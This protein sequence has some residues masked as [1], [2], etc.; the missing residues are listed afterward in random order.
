V[1]LAPD[2]PPLALQVK[3]VVNRP[4][5]DEAQHPRD[6]R[7]RFIQKGAEVRVGYGKI[8]IVLDEGTGSGGASD[9]KITV[10]F[11]DGS[12]GRYD[13]NVLTVTKAPTTAS[14][15][16]ANRDIAQPARPAAPPAPDRPAD[17]EA[18]RTAIQA[19]ADTVENQD[20]ATAAAL[21]AVATDPGLVQSADGAFVARQ[22]DDGGT[23][24]WHVYESSTGVDLTPTGA[25]LTS[26]QERDAAFDTLAR[27]GVDWHAGATGGWTNDA[28][29]ASA[30]QAALTAFA[31]ADTQPDTPTEPG[32]PNQPDQGNAPD[33]TP[34]APTP[35]PAPAPNPADGQQ[36][37]RQGRQRAPR[38]AG[39]GAGAPGGRQQPQQGG[40][41]QQGDAPDG[42]SRFGAFIMSVIAALKGGDK[43]RTEGDGTPEDPVRLPDVNPDQP[44]GPPGSI[45]RQVDH[46]ET[47]ADGSVTV[48]FTDG[49]T[50]TQSGPAD[51]PRPLD[52]NA[53]VVGT[54]DPAVQPG[55]PADRAA[56]PTDIP[57]P[58]TPPI[59]GPSPIG[60]QD[61]Q[62]PDQPAE[63]TPD[64][65][66]AQ[67]AQPDAIPAPDAAP[68]PDQP[69][70]NAR[71]AA[72]DALRRERE[73]ALGRL[74]DQQVED[75]LTAIRQRTQGTLDVTD[76][77]AMDLQQQ[78][79]AL[80][81]EALRRGL[82]SRD[83]QI[84]NGAQD[85]QVRP[86][87]DAQPGPDGVIH[88][89][90]ENPTTTIPIPG[91]PRPRAGE[92]PNAPDPS[93][94]MRRQAAPPPPAP[95]AIP[96]ADPGAPRLGA[97]PRG[98]RGAQAMRDKYGFDDRWTLIGGSMGTTVGRLR[99]GDVVQTRGQGTAAAPVELVNNARMAGDRNNV[100]RTVDRT[101]R[102]ADG[103]ITVHFTDGTSTGEE[104]GSRNGY[105]HSA[106]ER[107]FGAYVQQ[108][109]APQPGGDQPTQPGVPRF[110]NVDALRA[111]LRSHAPEALGTAAGTERE[112]ARVK[113]LDDLANDPSLRLSSDGRL[114]YVKGG[115]RGSGY[116]IL[117]PSVA[118][119]LGPLGQTLTQAEAKRLADLFSGLR[120]ADGQP[121]PWD[122]PDVNTRIASFR[123]ANGENLPQSLTR[124]RASDPTLDNS[125]ALGNGYFAEQVASYDRAHARRAA[126]TDRQSAGG[127]T[128][129][130]RL[131]AFQ[132][133]DRLQATIAYRRPTSTATGGAEGNAYYFGSD[134]GL[135][136]GDRV[137]VEGTVSVQNGV[138]NHTAR[139]GPGATWRTED[140]SRSGTFGPSGL[141]LYEGGST[142][143]TDLARGDAQPDQPTTPDQPTFPQPTG[144]T[145]VIGDRVTAPG[146]P[147]F[148]GVVTR[149]AGSGHLYVRLDSN[150][151]ESAAPADQLQVVEPDQPDQPPAPVEIDENMPADALAAEFDRVGQ[152]D[153]VTRLL[154]AQPGQDIDAEWAAV[155]AAAANPPG[156]TGDDAQ[157]LRDAREEV[158]ARLEGAGHEILTPE[159]RLTL[160]SIPHGDVQTLVGLSSTY[161]SPDR[162]R[163]AA[164][165]EL[166]RRGYSAEGVPNQGSPAGLTNPQPLADLVGQRVAINDGDG[167][168][169]IGTIAAAPQSG[170]YD[171]V[172]ADGEE[173]FLPE[174]PA[175][176]QAEPIQPDDPRLDAVAADGANYLTTPE[177][178]HQI[179]RLGQQTR[180]AYSAARASGANPFEDPAFRAANDQYAS[181]VRARDERPE[182]QGGTTGPGAGQGDLFDQPTDPT[183][184]IPPVGGG[185]PAG[186]QQPTE[187]IPVPQN[188]RAAARI[189]ARR[190]GVPGA[191]NAIANRL[192]TRIT[193]RT[194]PAGEAAIDASPDAERIRGA[195]TAAEAGLLPR[196]SQ[197]DGARAQASLQR[198]LDGD[199][200]HPL[201]AV[202]HQATIQILDMEAPIQV[203]LGGGP[204]PPAA[205]RPYSGT[206]ED[207]HPQAPSGNIY[208]VVNGPEGRHGQ[209]MAVDAVVNVTDA[210]PQPGGGSPDQPVT[211]PAPGPDVPQPGG[212][213]PDG[214]R[215][216][217][218]FGIGDHVTVDGVLPGTIDNIDPDGTVIGLRLDRNGRVVRVTADGLQ[219]YDATP[220]EPTTP[221]GGDLPPA[222]PVDV[223]GADVQPGQR[224]LIDGATVSVDHV[225]PEDGGS[226]LVI[227]YTGDDGPGQITVDPSAVL[228]GLQAAGSTGNEPDEPAPSVID[229]GLSDTQAYASELQPQQ[230]IYVDGRIATVT[231][232]QRSDAVTVDY[233]IGRLHRSMVL[234]PNATIDTVDDSNLPDP[235][236]LP[237][238]VSTARPALQTYQRRSIVAMGLDTHP[239]PVV[240]EAARRVRLRQPL[241]AE[242]ARAL[243]D[244]VR[245]EAGR[246]GVRP[247]QRRS[248]QRQAAVLD[249]AAIQAGAVYDPPQI[250]GQDTVTPLRLTDVVEGNTVAV[251][252]ATGA[253]LSGRV[254]GRRSLMGGRLHEVTVDQPDGT[255]RTLLLPRDAPAFLLPDLPDPTPVPPEGPTREH[256]TVDR[257]N[258][259]DVIETGAES[260][261]ASTGS[262]PW[263]VV[264]VQRNDGGNRYPRATLRLEDPTD[265]TTT[266]TR[267]V[268]AGDVPS[269]IRVERGDASAEQPFD[270]NMPAENPT[271]IDYTDVQAGDRITISRRYGTTTGYVESVKDITG[272]DDKGRPIAG[273]AF[274]VQTD[275]GAT[276][277]DS[278]FDP[279]P[280][281]DPADQPTVMRLV[282]ADEET[283]RARL[284][285]QAERKRQQQ[286]QATAR[287]FVRTDEEARNQALSTVSMSI[288]SGRDHALAILNEDLNAYRDDTS[289]ARQTASSRAR[290][291][292][293]QVAATERQADAI[294]PRLE[295]LMVETYIRG[296]QDVINALEQAHP[297][298]G[299]T[300][301]NMLRRVRD[302]LDSDPPDH[303]WVDLGS[304][305]QRVQAAL[306]ANRDETAADTPT[307]P[308][309]PTDTDIATRMRAYQDAIGGVFGQAQMRVTSF[310]PTTL[311]DLENG[312]VPDLETV[313]TGREDRAAD[314]GPGATAMA[315]HDIVKAAGRDLDQH[316]TRKIAEQLGTEDPHGT[317]KDLKDR[318]AAARTEFTTAL[319][320]KSRIANIRRNFQAMSAGYPN[321]DR[322]RYTA[323]G[324]YSVTADE[325][326]KA[327]TDLS[328]VD[329]LVL[330]DPEYVA[331]R[332]RMNAAN[333]AYSNLNL[334]VAAM[335]K[336]IND[337]L[338]Q[339]TLAALK[340]IRGFGGVN[341]TYYK[342][343][344]GT[345]TDLTE[346]SGLVKAMRWAEENYPTDWLEQ[347]K[348]K[349]PRVR[350]E[351]TSRGYNRGG[352][353]IRLSGDEGQQVSDAPK[354]GRVATHE[355]G[356]S[357][358]GHV[359][360]LRAAE[361]AYLWARSGTGEIGSRT[362]NRTGKVDGYP[363]YGN[364]PLS[365]SG[366]AYESASKNY[367][368]LTTGMESLLAGSG[369][370]DDD[371]RQWLLGTLATVGVKGRTLR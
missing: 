286:A 167:R 302:R 80:E 18:A 338:R 265:P 256:I 290:S 198:Y 132:N 263:R 16:E 267:T 26:E 296:Y 121:F 344:R 292:A 30:E 352:F 362:R 294:R 133:G 230:R 273:R 228:Q 369:Y 206:V 117:A 160:D 142:G 17:V 73:A 195:V 258:P 342:W 246:R 154:A 74:T 307:V 65:Q 343:G 306:E 116:E 48:H 249:A 114:A 218:G 31:I 275:D 43:V 148:E 69:A 145:P 3:R 180:D 129:V 346:R 231:G 192:S 62:Q 341:I 86:G 169:Q 309:L 339:Q 21:R 332:D 327:K 92:D 314:G 179:E 251:R 90:R 112:A 53:P 168:V 226:G 96:N 141:P 82:L 140:G 329:D 131:A 356:H 354:M 173:V 46:V 205:T 72:A 287:N 322:L 66:P 260:Y 242:Q 1:T 215:T 27:S 101:E 298:P 321:Y 159:Q 120:D 146:A 13:N 95:D 42:W 301:Q 36:Q 261:G 284:A 312:Q 348:A 188:P 279:F 55:D 25:N 257:L 23:S 100:N 29:R 51:N 368:I 186:G 340:E 253:I 174:L 217:N 220:D 171:L 345:S 11:A 202:G 274:T 149:D 32:S 189:I 214:P 157:R 6:R 216:T 28:D 300:E 349:Q 247:G 109:A 237:R 181:F 213:Q 207:V 170:G 45:W 138:G 240:A 255:Q 50:S 351:Q 250:D 291:L 24:T 334:Q 285:A 108:G 254:S 47:G 271:E 337:A 83:Q 333:D 324:T 137:I 93:I 365:Y 219:A 54:D 211:P 224:L 151:R 221:A 252:D 297:L 103:K 97:A 162:I 12:Q 79:L 153:V 143:L 15:A 347:S 126:V 335:D 316:L 111:H 119:G 204:Q 295:D 367:E 60:R 277:T 227:D 200:T 350:L 19:H 272:E 33:G 58:A 233:T 139:L 245:E 326:D 52:G 235:T 305:L 147:G 320:D 9:G 5:F 268:N 194:D 199:P 115:S 270:A 68:T 156:V 360:G 57:A 150:G 308:D 37:P 40:Q 2:R 299:E 38:G 44:D 88:L 319:T 197:W 63:P 234:S 34:T 318:Q 178:D 106:R 184:P 241:A 363:I 155:E 84:Q 266:M 4:T 330:A 236:P 193:G 283:L 238:D 164:E 223:T 175:T 269:V 41:G 358:E 357:M 144:R 78:R 49:T 311:A 110:A 323:Q 289:L 165:A 222:E 94:D 281:Q 239:R 118:L 232:V 359:P 185:Q 366:K 102:G 317:L 225:T 124:L 87:G 85:V 177:L 59:A 67:P 190:F 71:T 203:R 278:V 161:G 7:G 196:R 353:E 163:E 212:G 201:N 76:P 244:A 262:R 35:A 135:N 315:H 187:Q 264:D 123:A 328:R 210:A 61:Q 172:S 276:V 122:A 304:S 259:G 313:V 355:L 280:G 243:A 125:I 183:P 134:S 99:G 325:R 22:V 310:K 14:V 209:R 98:D 336:A 39:T 75:R 176:G 70:P 127:F 303:R 64:A 248:L 361:E 128:P 166:T 113:I 370:L 10:R 158:R 371:F 191:E 107:A 56:S 182:P 8:G 91:A 288:G 20:P 81:S 208:A 282:Q 293:T 104:G 364:W 229:S 331:A 152:A 136:D 130:N 105:A 89:T 77:A